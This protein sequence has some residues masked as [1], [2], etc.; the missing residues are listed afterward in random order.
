VQR[1]VTSIASPGARPAAL[2][3]IFLT[4]TLDILAI[5]IIIPV[6]PHLITDFAGGSILLAAP[7]VG[8][9]GTLFAGMQFLFSPLL[10][11]LSDRFGRRPVIL[12]SNLGLGLDYIFMALAPSLPWLIVGRIISGVS[13]ASVTTAH[14]YIADITPPEKR[15]GSYGMLGAAF[16][17]GFVI[18]PALGGIL[19]EIDVRLPFWVAAGL[20]L[21]N[22]VYGWLILPESLP[23]ERRARL[24]LRRANPIGALLLLRRY[25]G[26]HGL[27][28][29][30]FL[31]NLAH[32]VLPA[33]FVLYASFR[34]GWSERDV[35]LCLAAVGVCSALVQGG[36]VRRWVP[37]FGER[38]MLL[39]GLLMGALGFALYGWAPT[40]FWF[41]VTIPFM[42][43]W[44]FAGPSA[45][46]LIT[47]QVQPEEQGRLQ[48]ALMSLTG[49]AG[50][51]GPQL[52]AQTFA[53]SIAPGRGWQ[54]P[55]AAFY[56]AAAVLLLA[57]LLAWR[58]ARTP[59]TAPVVAPVVSY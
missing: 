13:S 44:G 48:G 37:R 30:L 7:M 4:V 6:L 46:G 11:A 19:G 41:I 43:L 15:A 18:G 42:A 54:L 20:S 40:G 45:Q 53:F 14:A 2:I 22:F 16:G 5:G 12:A 28:G 56:V 23:V 39:F 55:G 49:L 24:N 47:R 58:T 1:C 3:F 21:A 10:G 59:A 27:A 50:I 32:I 9:F 17:L 33:T 35:G 29:V 52:F 8:W 36:L 26:L 31:S 34:Y 57:L 51:F 38:R 25:P